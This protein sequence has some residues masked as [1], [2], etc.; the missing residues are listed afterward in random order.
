MTKETIEILT[1]KRRCGDCQSFDQLRFLEGFGFGWCKERDMFT[2]PD[3][4]ICDL[5]KR[6]EAIDEVI[7]IGME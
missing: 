3:W 6:K 2:A 1:D 5:F 4:G 7:G